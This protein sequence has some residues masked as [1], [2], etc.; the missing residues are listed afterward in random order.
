MIDHARSQAHV[1][2]DARSQAHM[3]D[4]ALRDLNLGKQEDHDKP[5]AAFN[6]SVMGHIVGKIHQLDDLVVQYDSVVVETLYLKYQS[7]FLSVIYSGILGSL[8]SC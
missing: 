7:D 2:D 8:E 3:I 1:T 6:F 5:Y 4:H